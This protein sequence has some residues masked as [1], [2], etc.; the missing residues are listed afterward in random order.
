MRHPNFE[1]QITG[2]KVFSELLDF[3]V[4]RFSKY[5]CYFIIKI[6]K[7]VYDCLFLICTGLEVWGNAE[8]VQQVKYAASPKQDGKLASNQTFVR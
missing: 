7:S 1:I 8:T 5:Y 3:S 6:F 2:M 4:F